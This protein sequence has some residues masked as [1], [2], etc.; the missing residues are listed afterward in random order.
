[1][2]VRIHNDQTP[3]VSSQQVSEADRLSSSRAGSAKNGVSSDSGGDRVDVS[4]VTDAISAG[5]SA[6]NLSQ[7]NRVAQLKGAYE[8]GQYAVDTAQVSKAV[9]GNAITGTTTGK[10]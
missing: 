5:I 7:A 10:A 2:S 1:M 3:G 8:G 6:Q 9:V 4:S